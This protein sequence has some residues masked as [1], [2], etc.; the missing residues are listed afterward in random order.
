MPVLV[1]HS[2]AP[3][4]GQDAQHLANGMAHHGHQSLFGSPH[5]ASP[6]KG[7]DST[8][9]N[10][11]L[12]MDSCERRRPDEEESL[13]LSANKPHPNLYGKTLTPFLREHIPGIYAPIGKPET[14]A[15]EEIKREK[16]PNSKMCYRHRPDSK[17]RRAADEKKMARI[18]TVRIPAP[19]RLLRNC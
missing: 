10:Y 7:D 14:Q 17:C 8:G 15:S 11:H 4:M 1:N 3:T 2:I 16:D 19:L 9:G 13:R 18:Q 12:P 5:L 6:S